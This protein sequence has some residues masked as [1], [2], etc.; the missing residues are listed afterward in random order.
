MRL[1]NEV[2]WLMKMKMRKIKNRSQ[3]YDINRPRTGYRHKYAKYK[4]CLSIIMVICI[5]QHLSNIWSSIRKKVKH[6]EAEL[7]KALLIKKSV[8]YITG[9][10]DEFI[11]K[12]YLVLLCTLFGIFVVVF[13]RKSYVFIIFISL[14]DEVS[15][16]RNIIL[17]N[18]KH[19]LVVSNCQWNYM[20][21][22][23]SSTV[24]FGQSIPVSDWFILCRGNLIL[25]QKDKL[26]W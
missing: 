19:E 18:Q 24:N 3:R 23:Y 9:Q 5:K 8:Y 21:L 11:K 17:T 13:H 26:K 10:L 25:Y 12:C 22:A 7:K 14:F 20:F 2:T 1:S 16:S 6:T 4:M 15:Y